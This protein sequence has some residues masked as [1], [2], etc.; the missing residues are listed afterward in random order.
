MGVCADPGSYRWCQALSRSRSSCAT[1]TNQSTRK[2]TQQQSDTISESTRAESTIVASIFRGATT[3][4]TTIPTAS[5][6]NQTPLKTAAFTVKTTRRRRHQ[7]EDDDVEEDVD[8]CARTPTK[9]CRS[10]QILKLALICLFALLAQNA[11]AHNIPEDAVHITAILGEGVVFNCHVEFPND[12]PVPY[13]LQWDKKVSETV[14]Y[15]TSN[16]FSKLSFLHCCLIT[17]KA[18]ESKKQIDKSRR[19][20]DKC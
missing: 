11:Q 5:T 20:R 2:Q 18:K 13:V 10:I 3:T 15:H 17:Q 12:H 1:N 6:L 8:G 14:R 7:D 9:T 19:K 4:T 16:F